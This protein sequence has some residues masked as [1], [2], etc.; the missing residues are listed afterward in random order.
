MNF[1]LD[2]KDSEKN[3]Q[4]AL[5]KIKLLKNGDIA[6]A[7]KRT[8]IEYK[9]NWGVSLV[10]LRQMAREF[11]PDHILALKLWNKQWRET[12]ILATLLDEPDKVNEEQ[13]DYWTKTFENGEIAELASTHLWVKSKFAF[14]KALE[15]CRGKKHL[16]RFTG[17]HLV[18]RLAIT[19]KQA[20]DEMFESFF[21]EFMTLAKDAKLY[22]VLYRTLIA[23]GTRSKYLNENTVELAQTLQL[24]SSEN[25]IK[26]GEAIYEELTSEYVQERF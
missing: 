8:G 12:S 14:V 24:S 23:L 17:I 26:L 18:G 9:M 16:V 25:A 13:M 6:D 15:W 1:I 22:T 2:N 7:M 21:E 11:E 19:D 10:I 3:F 20:I 5:S 4:L